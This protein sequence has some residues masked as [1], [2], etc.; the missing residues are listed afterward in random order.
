MGLGFRLRGLGFRLMGWIRVRGVGVWGTPGKLG[1]NN[2][3]ASTRL[4]SKKASCA[5]QQLCCP[6]QAPAAWFDWLRALRFAFRFAF[7][8]GFNLGSCLGK[9]VVVR[10]GVDGRE[11]GAC[12]IPAM[13]DV[14][15]ESQK[16]RRRADRDRGR[17]CVCV[18]VCLSVC[19]C[20]CVCGY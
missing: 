8:L 11:L 12:R 20:V 13:P 14:T 17:G 9:L 19:L 10:H 16:A 7:S 4:E 1:K 3:K 18:C 6:T 2:L 5:S 15:P